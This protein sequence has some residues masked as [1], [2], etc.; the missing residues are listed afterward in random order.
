MTGTQT[1]SGGAKILVAVV[2]LA[3]VAGGLWLWLRPTP[4]APG[5]LFVGDSVTYLSTKELDRETKQEHPIV[6]A[7]IGFRSDEMLPRFQAEVDRRAKDG[8]KDQLAQVA[9]LIGYNDVLQDRVDNPALGRF[10]EQAD[11]FDCAVWLTLPVV[12]MH[13]DGTQRWNE[14]VRAAAKDHPNVHVVDDW[15]EAVEA[16]DPGE[17]IS[18]KDGVHP[19]AAGGKR[20]A[21]IYVD[22]VHRVC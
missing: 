1:P 3:V 10:L 18:R 12:P 14:R 5:I 15:R 22:A 4:V 13:D 19:T 9:I 2:A 6:L 8:G 21:S 17:L 7:R 16:A 11:R 20:L